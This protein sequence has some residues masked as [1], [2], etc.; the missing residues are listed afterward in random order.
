MPTILILSLKLNS[1]KYGCSSL[2][3]AHQ[4]AQILIKLYGFSFNKSFKKIF[5]SEYKVLKE[6]LFLIILSLLSG[7]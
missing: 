7:M 4:D 1:I 6:I 5:S 3:G 2:Q